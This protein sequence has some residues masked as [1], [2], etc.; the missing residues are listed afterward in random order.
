M[1]SVIL[2][3]GSGTR[4][5]P[6]SR[7]NY[8]K[9]FLNLFGDK[10]LIQETYLRIRDIMP[11]ED[12]FFITNQEGFFNVYN[13]IKEIEK[14]F[15]KDNIFI[16]PKAMNTAP[17]M[18][19]AIKNLEDKFGIAPDESIIFLPSDHYIKNGEAYSRVVKEALKNVDDHIGTIGITPT[20]PNVSYGYIKKGERSG[21]FFKVSEFKEKP[22]KITAEKYLESGDYVW[23][24]GMYLFNSQTFM[25]EL[26]KHCQELHV[27]AKGK[28]S[29]FLEKFETLPSISIDYA[30]S[31]KSDNVVVFEGAF[32]W[33]DIGSFDSL[34]ETFES[35]PNEK[36]VN[37]DSENIFIHSDSDRLVATVGVQDLNII[38]TAD[39]ILIQ[40]RGRGEDVK[41]VVNYLKE[42]KMKELEDIL[43]VHRPWGRFE[44]LI[45]DSD[46]KV[47][48]IIVHPGAKLSLQSHNRRSE[49]WVVVRGTAEIING[50]KTLHLKENESTYI[51]A[52]NKHRLSNSG[53]INLEIIEVQTG[54][55]LEED[56][57]VRY[58]DIYNRA[59]NNST[60]NS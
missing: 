56:D 57:I 7:K 49:H 39:S 50:E 41:K 19:L 10:T 51:P 11:K 31:E 9:Q 29:D 28:L 43:I 14:E 33:N 18:A 38:E 32:D 54:D 17:A 3:G 53:D 22:D 2:C 23:N 4:L 1:K 42:H 40:K 24:A 27:L 15:N 21:L 55:Y 25:R 8:P 26:K 5:W 36:H 45:D 20:S 48:K 13:Q 44:V 46:H 16:E 12:I 30:I 35:R 60:A 37:V 52:G 58:D 47:K 59:E 34:Y 6:L